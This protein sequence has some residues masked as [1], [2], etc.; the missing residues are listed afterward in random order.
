[1]RQARLPGPSLGPFLKSIGRRGWLGALAAAL[2]VLAAPLQAQVDP[3]GRVGRLNLAEGEVAFSPAGSEAWQAARTTRPL[4]RGDRIWTHH[5]ARSELSLGTA[6]L[7]AQGETR[8]GILELDDERAR[9]ELS[10][11]TLAIQVRT[12]DR[13]ERFE[14]TTPDLDF[15][16]ESPGDYRIEVDPE[17]STT[18]VIVRQ[19]KGL[20]LEGSGQRPLPAPFHGRYQNGNP[21]WQAADLPWRDDFDRWVA[22]RMERELRA[23]SSRYLSRDMVGYEDLDD[24]GDWW[25]DPNYGRVWAPRISIVGW[26]PYRYGHWAWIAPWGWTWVDDAPWG[27]A[28]FHY[29]R[30]ALVRSHWVWVPGPVLVRPYYAPALVV[31]LGGPGWRLSATSGPTVAWFPLG[32]GEAYQPT[33]RASKGYYT[34]LNRKI[35][36]ERE[37]SHQKGEDQDYRNRRVPG[38]VTALPQQAFAEGRKVHGEALHVP[39]DVLEQAPVAPKPAPAAAR[40]DGWQGLNTERHRETPFKNDSDP[41]GRR[42]PKSAPEQG[43]PARA[44]ERTSGEPRRFREESLPPIERP[45]PVDQAPQP[46]QGERQ[47]P[48]EPA[49]EIRPSSQGE[50]VEQQ[51][52]HPSQPELYRPPAPAADPRREAGRPEPQDPTGRFQRKPRKGDESEG[53]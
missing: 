52:Q 9:F 29:G 14:I 20:A 30:W 22:N 21:V 42:P 3:P 27:F 1:M 2:L 18:Q 5:G 47:R 17:S 32:P 7:R 35:P 36:V 19:G 10:R 41:T 24:H 6:V 15:V 48:R 12:L 8:L 16:I 37:M 26:A 13:E 49:R 51:T 43:E 53:R 50:R 46:A 34:R 45:R 39:Q 31:F 40:G 4:T 33:Y 11:G 25:D 23:P 28:P 38:A 44:A